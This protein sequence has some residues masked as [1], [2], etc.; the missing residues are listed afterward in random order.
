M[1]EGQHVSA[2][3]LE[4]GVITFISDRP[5]GGLLWRKCQWQTQSF[6]NDFLRS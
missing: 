4:R 3:A 1:N 5:R 6:F 2:A